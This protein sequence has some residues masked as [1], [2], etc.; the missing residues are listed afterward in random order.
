[1]TLQQWVAIIDPPRRRNIL[2]VE[3]EPFVREAT[4]SILQRAGFDVLLAKDFHEALA[5]YDDAMNRI[6]PSMNTAIDM[7][8]TDMILP[9]GTGEQLAAEIHQRSPAM[10]ILV[11]S[12]YSNLEYETESP[13]S[14]TFF[15]AKPY[16]RRTLVEKIEKIL[17]MP[18]P[19]HLVAQ[20]G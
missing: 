20:A 19:L 5:V 11:T 16:S 13:G 4:C 1:M 12:G 17:K 18:P 15:L 7:V 2:L 3:D 9:G 6:D 14:H 8:M 10:T